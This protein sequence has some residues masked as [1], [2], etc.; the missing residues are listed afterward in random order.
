MPRFRSL[1][2]LF[3]CLLLVGLSGFSA[4]RI[5][6]RLGIADL[7]ATGLHRLDLYA[8]SLEREIGKYAFLP[9]T[10]SL[11]PEVIDLLAGGGD[12]ARVNAYL[13]KLNERA[14]TLSIYVMDTQG[15]VL[16]TS[17]W[18][19]PDSFLG[20]DLSFRPYFREALEPA[21]GASSASAPRAAS[22]ATTWPRR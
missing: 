5:G 17:N 7:Q 10:L 1:P 6:Q 18:R 14:G 4:Y 9:G 16:A 15:K 11:A 13:E 21:A 8:T 22:R 20:E 19:R 12:G 3:V 2:L